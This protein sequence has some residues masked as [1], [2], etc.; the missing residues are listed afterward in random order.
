MKAGW[1]VACTTAG[2]TTGQNHWG[3]QPAIDDLSNLYDYINTNYTL[4]GKVV[5]G[6]HSMGNLL[7]MNALRLGSTAF[8]NVVDGVIHAGNGVADLDAIF[9]SGNTSFTSAICTAY[10]LTCASCST[11]GTAGCSDWVSLTG[12]YDPVD[13]AASSWAAYRFY[14][15][16]T[17]ADT[18]IDR[19]V[20][21]AALITLITGNVVS[22][23]SITGNCNHGDSA[24]PGSPTRMY[25]PAQ[26]LAQANDMTP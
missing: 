6:A 1:Y 5:V 25:V 7:T 14:F 24:C 20:H 21:P 13:Q 17:S 12:N 10:A 23:N 8:K 2:G 26:W 9:N 16:T 15:A 11:A 19:A 3:S 4:N 22:L 18:L